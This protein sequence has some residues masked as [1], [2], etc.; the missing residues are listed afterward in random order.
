M[1]RVA[2]GTLAPPQPQAGMGFPTIPGVVYNGVHHTGDLFDFGPDFDKGLISVQP[3]KLVGSPYPV[4]VPKT[5]ADGNDVAGLRLPEVIGADRDLHR[6]GLARRRPRR[7]RRQRPALPFAKTKAERLASGDPRPSLEER[8]KD[9][10][11]YVEMVTRAAQ[12]L[13][14]QRLML[15]EDVQATIAA[16][17]AAQVP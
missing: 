17:Q 10:A 3:P 4:L 5:D 2:D 12:E 8:Y 16:A 9:H 14:A 1:P 6:L 7:L 15:D 13:K 11:T